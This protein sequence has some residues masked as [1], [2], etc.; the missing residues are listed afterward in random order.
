M[1]AKVNVNVLL[2]IPLKER[3]E[4]KTQIRRWVK[5]ASINGDIVD[6]CS[7]RKVMMANTQ[8]GVN[9]P[10]TVMKR[11]IF[12]PMTSEIFPKSGQDKKDKIPRTHSVKP[13]VPF[14]FVGGVIL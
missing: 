6:F 10:K 4:I 11:H 2:K 1:Y 7:S 5:V 12:L 8:M 9:V 14:V 3:S 13:K